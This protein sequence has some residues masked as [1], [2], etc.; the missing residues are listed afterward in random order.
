MKK[1]WNIGQNA[2]HLFLTSSKLDATDG[3]TMDLLTHVVQSSQLL[4][5]E[6]WGEVQKLQAQML[7]HTYKVRW[8]ISD[9]ACLPA[10]IVF[11][12]LVKL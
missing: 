2:A 6:N 11:E 10:A 1:E 3:F 9:N 8:Q 4:K 5:E 12:A 7:P